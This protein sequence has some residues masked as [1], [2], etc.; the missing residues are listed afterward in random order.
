MK[1][2]DN[3]S[4]SFEQNS[5]KIIDHYDPKNNNISIEHINFILI[6][7]AGVGKSSF[8]NQS[9]LLENNKKAKEGDG[10]S[11]TKESHL[12]TSDKL[13]S[14]RMWDS[15]GIDFKRN[16]EVILNEIKNLVNNGLKEGPDSYINIILYCTNANGKRFQKEEGGLIQKIMQLYP[17]DNL[18]VIITQLQ[19]YF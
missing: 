6:G 3:Y 17:S 11:V 15:A 12:Y 19:A 7:P 2:S 4:L 14:V 13:T 1:Q 8:I 16:P 5:K 18:P 10:E 9:L